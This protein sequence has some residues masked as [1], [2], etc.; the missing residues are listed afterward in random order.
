MSAVLYDAVAYGM[1]YWFLLLIAL[2]FFTLAAVSLSEYRQRK[3]V[4]GIV[5]Q[6]IGYLEVVGGDEESIGM[7]I[8][9]MEENLI[10]SGK[11]AD[12][13]IDDPLVAKTHARLYLRDGGLFLK[14]LGGN[15]AKINGRLAVREHEILTGDVLTFGS[16]S[17]TVYLMDQE[18][19]GEDDDA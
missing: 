6:Y 18:E 7:R 14:P 15:R 16:V 11:R 19:R 5:K 17:C 2:M 1:R 3:S 9:L 8:G 13:L 12:I 10:G 4:M